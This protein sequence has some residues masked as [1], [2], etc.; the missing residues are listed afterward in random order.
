MYRVKPVFS[1]TKLSY[2]AALATLQDQE[3][4]KH[5]RA[6]SVESREYLYHGLKEFSQLEVFKSYANYLLVDV[7]K[8]GMKS[9][10]ITK[11]LMKRS[12]IVRNCSSFRGLDDY[13]IRVSVG[14]L[15]EDEQFLEI[16]KEMVE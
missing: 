12:I 2:V 3:Y 1:L 10:Q 15:K 7:R 6:V 9:A 4:I 14:T 8:T 5:S 13:W 11:E 16:L